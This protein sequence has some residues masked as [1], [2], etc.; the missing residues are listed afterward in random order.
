MLDGR[1]E[2]ACSVDVRQPVVPQQLELPWPKAGRGCVL[3]PSRSTRLLN[4]NALRPKG[5][6][7][8]NWCDDCGPV[9]AGPRMR[10]GPER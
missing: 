9:D 10:S 8:P 4:F 1:H 2:G 7:V 5:C 3:S 6:P